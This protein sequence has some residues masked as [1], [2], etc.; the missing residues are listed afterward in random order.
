MMRDIVRSEPGMVL[1]GDP[2]LDLAMEFADLALTI[3]GAPDLDSTRQ[4]IVELAVDKGL[5]S[6]A[7]LWHLPDRA[8][9]LRLDAGSDAD[10]AAGLAELVKSQPILAASCW[11][12]Q[13]NVVVDDFASEQRWPDYTDY[14]LRH[15]PVRSAAAFCL[16]L[17]DQL[18]GVLVCYADKP[19]EFTMERLALASIFAVHASIGLHDAGRSDQAANLSKALESNRRIGMAIG[20]LVALYKVTEQQGFDLMRIASQR[21]HVKLHEVADQV[22]LTGAA[23]TWPEPRRTPGD[24]ARRTPSSAPASVA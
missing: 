8:T 2:K 15:T 4:R 19:H 9:H 17:D 18:A 6:R 14:I 13:Q 22:I 16:G 5:C 20:V 10:F 12:N 1:S 23:P 7:A 3:S 11:A 21:T 24:Q